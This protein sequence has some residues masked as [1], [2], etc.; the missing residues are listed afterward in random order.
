MKLPLKGI[1]LLILLTVNVSLKADTA[2]QLG[3]V[4]QINATSDQYY[5]DRNDKRIKVSILS[6]LYKG[7]A[8][9]VQDK[10]ASISL[11]INGESI[12]VSLNNSPYT[13]IPQGKKSM[14]SGLADKITNILGGGDERF[15]IGAISR[16][17]G[18]SINALSPLGVKVVGRDALYF[19]WKNGQ[20]PYYFEVIDEKTKRIIFK[21]EMSNM[22]TLVNIPK[23]FP[24]YLLVS[25]KSKYQN[26]L[27]NIRVIAEDQLPKFSSEME[28][29]S[30]ATSKAMYAFWL[31]TQ[32]H[33][34]WRF[35]AIQQLKQLSNENNYLAETL[36]EKLD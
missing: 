2:Q 28:N 14:L 1:L 33:G 32:D 20:A 16:G 8:V 7:D 4:E 31:Y 18:L 19:S 26:K 17:K 24:D 11:M 29:I 35:E 23:P 21:K 9:V 15:N 3:W 13:I 5:I 12:K 36:L 6:P 22:N 25:I 34:A 10:D 27:Y 30:L